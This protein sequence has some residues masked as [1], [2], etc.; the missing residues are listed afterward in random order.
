MARKKTAAKKAPKRARKAPATGKKASAG[1]A[2]HH[3]GQAQVTVRH[4]CQGIGDCHLLKF[5]KSDGSP[6]WMMID[7]GIHTSV[8]GGSATIDKIVDDVAKNT[9]GRLDVIAATHEHADHLSG[10]SSAAVKFGKFKVGEIWMGWTENPSDKQAQAL[11][12]YKEQAVAALQATHQALSSTHE[13]NGHLGAVRNGLKPLLEFQ[14][15]AKGDKVRDMRKN[16]VK[17]APRN[18]RYFEPKDPPIT[19]DGL[20]NLRVYVLGPPRDPNLI[21]VVERKS[22]MYGLSSAGLSTA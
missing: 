5:T 12:K 11:D 9:G 15:G 16:L 13:L 4:Y 1:A 3:N 18:V 20:P 14:F 7:C 17:L 8:K 21:K 2:T 10:F 6:Y 19:I 22:E